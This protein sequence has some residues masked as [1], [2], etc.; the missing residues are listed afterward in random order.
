MCLSMF[1][2]IDSKFQSYSLVALVFVA[3]VQ[4][5]WL[6]KPPQRIFKG[7]T[8]Q[9]VQTNIHDLI[10]LIRLRPTGQTLYLALHRTSKN[11]LHNGIC[12]SISTV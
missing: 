3:P 2:T 11:F 6:E 9:N 12:I 10:H 8:V 4:S 5:L 1:Q 7:Y